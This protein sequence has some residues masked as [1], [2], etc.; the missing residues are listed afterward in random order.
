MAKANS[1]IHRETRRTP[2]E[3]LGEERHRLHQ[4][5]ERPFTAVFGKTRSMH[6]K[7]S[8]IRIEQVRYS[9]PH[10]HA[11]EQVWVRWHGDELVVTGIAAG[12]PA[13]IIRHAR[14]TPGNPVILDVHYPESA[15]GV[16]VPTPTNTAEEAFPA[17][18]PGASS[19]LEEAA[20]EGVRGIAVALAKLR[21]TSQVDRALGTAA[22]AG[23][24]AE[25]DPHSILDHQAFHEGPAAPVRP[26]EDHSLQP[27]T[28]AWSG[29]GGTA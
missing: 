2:I 18:G 26:G 5:P 13:E 12:A 25:S 14:S 10:Q 8:T 9:V 22:I 3:M 17:I 6:D 11:G 7:E 1:R 24:F 21:G 15:R 16:H 27:G 28:D 23:R 29:F 20:A 19:W 4:V